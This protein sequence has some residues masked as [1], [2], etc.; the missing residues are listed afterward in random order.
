[1]PL[2][3][4][5]RLRDRLPGLLLAALLAGPLAG[6]AAAAPPPPVEPPL[7]TGERA[8][9]DG[10]L[11]IANEA[12]AA[13]PQ[14]TWAD[15]DAR[16][17]RAWIEATRGVGKRSLLF[18][19]NADARSM[20]KA[21]PKLKKL[22]RPGG[23]LWIYLSGHGGLLP[24]GRPALLGT[25]AEP[26]APRGLALDE[27]V[28]AAGKVGAERVIVLVDAGFGPTGRGGFEL[29]APA[30]EAR[31]L[32]EAPGVLLWTATRDGG[33]P[34]LYAPGR[35]GL[36]TWSLLGALR[37][38]ADGELD[39]QPDGQVSAEEAAAFV[40]RAPALLGR[41]A[42]PHAPLPAGAAG[43]TLA[44]GGAGGALQ[45]APPLATF[46][47]LAA[48]DAAAR[49]AAAEAR[50][51]EEAAAFWADAQA[52]LAAGGPGA[53]AALRAFIAEFERPVVKVER[54]VH[55]AEVQAARQRLAGGAPAPVEA[56]PVAEVTARCDDLVALEGPAMLG[57]LPPGERECLEKRLAAERLQ[58]T[59]SKVSRLLIVNAE[60]KADVGAWERL[61]QRHLQDI[62]RSDPDLC[63]RYAIH[64]HK[65]GPELGEDAIRWADVA[66]ENKQV[67]AGD[68]HV[69][70]VAGLYRLRAEAAH[71]L[72]SAA[73][74]AYRSDGSPDSDRAAREHRGAAMNFSREWLDYTRAS[75]KPSEAALQL[76]RTAAGTDDYCRAA[77]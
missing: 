55:L 54:V 75:G 70:K 68:E 53:E 11:I 5:T 59:R 4:L 35:H 39:G 64:L 7:R 24:D 15:D 43:W 57:E 9:R 34:E 26:G 6:P 25:D 65:Q 66:L 27:L 73:E 46:D 21:L 28:A 58:T 30:A 44:M 45:P 41:P 29:G 69:K 48:E 33:A 50:V 61:V 74:A 8:P 63:M 3:P 56:G 31:P 10:A 47:A 2:R 60:V 19:P 71:K 77:R 40:R 76:C 67:W 42:A 18:V 36:F 12:Y 17:V 72:W 16:A 14:A 51:R 23:T 20:E 49:L 13:L 62:D 1:M 32:P 52:Q 37:G 22:V 38:W